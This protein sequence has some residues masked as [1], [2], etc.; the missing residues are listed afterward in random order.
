MNVTVCLA[1]HIFPSQFLNQTGNLQA[2]LKIGAD[3]HK[4]DVKVPHPQIP[5]YFLIGTVPNLCCRRYGQQILHIRLHLVYNHHFISK[6]DHILAKMM[7][8]PS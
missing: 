3:A 7:P 1:Y 4:T 8:K 6:A 2:A 5:K